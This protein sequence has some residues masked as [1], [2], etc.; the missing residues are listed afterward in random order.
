MTK[1]QP[2]SNPE[3]IVICP[4]CAI[5]YLAETYPQDPAPWAQTQTMPAVGR[6][7]EKKNAAH[8]VTRPPGFHQ[9]IFHD[10]ETEVEA[11]NGTR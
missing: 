8:D 3:A 1:S 10:I 6:E 5:G 9:G 11:T 2:E 7:N 4:E